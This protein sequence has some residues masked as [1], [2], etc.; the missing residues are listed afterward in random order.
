MTIWCDND[1]PWYDNHHEPYFH[2]TIRQEVACFDEVKHFIQDV[3]KVNQASS[4]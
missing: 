1:T 2:L 3:L 4:P